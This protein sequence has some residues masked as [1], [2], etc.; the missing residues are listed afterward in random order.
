[1][2]FSNWIEV[3][4]GTFVVALASVA[5]ADIG[6]LDPAAKPGTKL[7]PGY[8]IAINVSVGGIDE[9]E[10]CGQFTLDKDA[11]FEYTLGF[12]PM[13]K[14][15]LAGLTVEEA[16]QKILQAIKAYFASPPEIHLGIAQMP[17]FQ[18]F[19]NGA[20]FRIGVI[21]L[22]DGSRLSDLLAEAGYF[23]TADLHSVLIRRVD[24]RGSP[25]ILR[26][27]FAKVLNVSSQA[28]DKF[29]AP[30]LQNADSI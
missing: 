19:I 15:A 12:K 22:P 6:M 1:M 27:D 26:A 3:I 5:R 23:P 10:L 18:V 4:L 11:K 16:R 25:S 21:T 29:N 14:V 28:D 30:P 17:R 9:R 2:K 8:Q 13:E 20:V 7:G 24:P